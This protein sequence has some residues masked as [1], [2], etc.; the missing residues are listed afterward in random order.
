M[1]RAY[2]VCG[3]PGTG[4]TVYGKKLAE[5]IGAAFLDIDVSTERLVSLALELAGHDSADR[6]SS[7]FKMHFR[8]PIY[9]QLFDIARDNL[10]HINVV[11][12][13]PFTKELMNPEWCERLTERLGC[14]VEIHYVSC[15]PEI[16]RKRMLK[17]GDPRDEAKLRDWDEYVRYYDDEAPPCCPHV[18]VVNSKE[19]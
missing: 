16:R 17:R 1:T 5:R 11:I 2:I 7:F 14:P 6:D 18:L 9:E 15:A 8:E 13:G 10:R 4:K 3:S 12:A 19:I